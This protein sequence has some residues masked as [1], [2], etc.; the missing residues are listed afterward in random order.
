MDATYKGEFDEYIKLT[1]Q[2]K[3]DAEKTYNQNLE[4]ATQQ[5]TAVGVSEELSENIATFH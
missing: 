1:K 4:L 5:L 3:E 2:T